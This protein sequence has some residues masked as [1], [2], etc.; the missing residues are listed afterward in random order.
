MRSLQER[1]DEKWLPAVVV[2]EDDPCWVWIAAFNSNGYG[3]IGMGSKTDGTRR[4][5]NAHRV[6]YELYRGTIPKG[7]EPDHLCRFRA[8]VNPWHMEPVTHSVNVQR[9]L[10]PGLLRA[11]QLAKTHC[12][13]GH[14]YAGSNLYT[15]KEGWRQC[16]TCS[17]SRRNRYR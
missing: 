17:N 12:P 3:E 2:W 16:R 15:T 11:R 8:C 6:G 13:S 5:H 7:L 14:P 9:G 1:F 10:A 4:P